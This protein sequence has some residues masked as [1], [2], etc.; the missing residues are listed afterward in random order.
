MFGKR[1]AN[2][3]GFDTFDRNF[4]RTFTATT[5]FIKVIFA[6]IFLS[7]GYTVYVLFTTDCPENKVPYIVGMK[8]VCVDASQVIILRQGY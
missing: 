3:H 1:S 5:I 6:L 4:N 7:I 2:D 8:T